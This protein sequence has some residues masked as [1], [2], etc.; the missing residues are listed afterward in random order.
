MAENHYQIKD[1]LRES[2]VN[3]E[4]VYG[5]VRPL[6]RSDVNKV[7]SPLENAERALEKTSVKSQEEKQQ[8]H[9]VIRFNKAFSKAVLA[10]IAINQGARGEPLDDYQDLT[11]EQKIEQIQRH[12][13]IAETILSG[14]DPHV[15]DEYLVDS[16]RE[17]EDALHELRNTTEELDYE[18]NRKEIRTHEE[19]HT[20][21]RPLPDQSSTSGSSN[22]NFVLGGVLA[23]IGIVFTM[24]GIGTT[25]GIL[26]ILLGGA[27]MFPT[28]A[29]VLIGLMVG[30]VLFLVL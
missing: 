14:L 23:I 15:I 20:R 6:T 1:W 13:D 3:F 2:D 9:D 12:L 22:G 24:T 30:A 7:L 29:A 26:L 28:L 16:Y 18:I 19:S 25:F 27:I 11:L 17:I 10:L 21:S 5:S 8:I 4:E